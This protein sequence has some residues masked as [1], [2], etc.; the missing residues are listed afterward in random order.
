MIEE[1]PYGEGN[2]QYIRLGLPKSGVP[3]AAAALVHGGYW[4]ERFTSSLMYPLEERLLAAGWI[5]VNIEYRRGPCNPWPIPSDDVG[6]A[7]SMAAKIAEDNG[8]G[9]RLVSIGHSVGGQL[10]LLNHRSVDAV[11]ALA[12][13]T[14]AAR[15][16]A[17]DL[18]DH[19]AQEYFQTS[20]ALRPDLFRAASPIGA[21]P[22]TAPT[23]IV[24]G[25]LDDRVPPQHTES[26][27]RAVDPESRIEVLRISGAGHIELIDPDAEH[28]TST[29]KWMSSVVS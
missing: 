10:A 22:P 26:Y 28:W 12:P 4:R 18:G 15:V 27:L 3:R 24:Q 19:A 14:D 6:D 29:V 20:P 13:V 25:M 23:L 16:Y 17:E 11:V 7:M 8:V 21:S 2:D 1:W 5:T 9:G